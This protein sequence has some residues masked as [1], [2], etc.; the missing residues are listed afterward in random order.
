VTIAKAY[1][2]VAKEKGW[3]VSWREKLKAH[4]ERA[5][6]FGA[7]N[8]KLWSALS[9]QMNEES[10]REEAARVNWTFDEAAQ[11]AEHLKNDLKLDRVLFILGGWIHRG[12]DNQHPDVLPAAP[13]C[14]GDAGLADCARRVRQLGYLFCL[15]DNYQDM[16]RDAPS[17]DPRFLM[18]RPDGSPV[19]GG[20]WAGGRA[21]ITCSRKALELAKRPQNLPAVKRLTGADAYFIDTTYAA[22]L[23]ECFDPDHPLSRW[24][25]MKWKQA[26]SDYARE[27]FGIFGSECGR[28]WAIPHSDFF[29]GLTGVSGHAYHDAG[30]EEKLGASVVP[31][32]EIVYRDCIAMYGKYGYD[33]SLAADYVLRHI[34]IGRPLNYHG[35]PGHLYWRATANQPENPAEAALFTH[36]RNG[37]AEGLH[38]V[39]RFLKNTVEILTPLHELTAQFSLVE[40]R[41]LTTDRTV[42]RTVFGEGPGAVTVVVNRGSA[43]YEVH[44]RQGGSIVLPRYGFLV[45]A[46]TFVAF[47]ACRWSG[48]DYETPPLFTL[49]SLDGQPLHRAR[50][51]RVYHGFGDV[52]VMAGGR[53]RTVVKEAVVAE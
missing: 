40:H 30:L 21:Y 48:V 45:E 52:R 47:H 38:P 3:L 44:S 9:R 26:L 15:H 33:V 14:G 13:E 22:G 43:D 2:Q 4:P 35:I 28:E 16:Y 19:A 27:Q 10:T 6:L 41:F 7:A 32:F 23:S 49:R 50:R 18:K 5:R 31:L 12:Y 39:D 46:P 37:W 29:E 11:V 53:L 42:E 36:A 51:V 20:R 8:V 24:D 17:W 1:R 25:D 34:S